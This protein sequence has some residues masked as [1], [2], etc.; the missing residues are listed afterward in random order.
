MLAAAGLVVA[1]SG[2]SARPQA[3]GGNPPMEA[4]GATRA[5]AFAATAAQLQACRDFGRSASE[6][7]EREKCAGI[8][9]IASPSMP[10][11][12]AGAG[13]IEE[14]AR[15]LDLPVTVLDAAAFADDAA[16]RTTG[17]RPTADT[18]GAACL[19]DEIIEAGG[20]L[21]YPAV[22]TYRD[23]RPLGTA[24]LGFKTG[25]AYASIIRERLA[26]TGVP[27][28]GPDMSGSSAGS[29]R[30]HGTGGGTG[31]EAANAWAGR[32]MRDGPCRD[33]AMPHATPQPAGPKPPPSD[34]LQEL[35]ATDI[36]L[37]GT[38]GAYFRFVHGRNA[39]SYEYDGDTYLIDLATGRT[40]PTPGFV[41]F[42]PSPDGRFF[43]TPAARNGGLLFYD[44]DAV[45]AGG[46]GRRAADPDFR[47]RAMRDQYP[48]VGILSTGA[49][50]QPASVRYRILT[51]WFDKVR[52]RDYDVTFAAGSN[53]SRLRVEP[54]GDPVIAC[55][56]LQVSIPMLSPD[57]R[58]LAGRNERTGRTVIWRLADNGGCMAV[59]SLAY[60]TSKVAWSPDGSRIAFFRSEGPAQGNGI[61]AHDRRTRRLT[62]LAS[63]AEAHRLAFP[64]FIG[65]DSVVFIATGDRGRR[66]F[67]IVCCLR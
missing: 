2:A 33:G 37:E 42:I 4:H 29:A 30:P 32:A 14:A 31:P 6:Q 26:G 25:D 40:I 13:E 8:L 15:R 57:G 56:E 38:P 1:C 18:R 41:D 48:S 19:R 7:V 60:G 66:S 17:H 55:P 61:L 39:I 27:T 35:T 36:A 59:D 51:S 67:R 24:L 21:H 28:D 45:F 9:Y 11:S 53:G 62:R 54:V 20:T 12:A 44:A 47:D 43:V 64:D 34:A 46:G 63:S 22:L 52:F 5:A 16:D 65:R 3:V 10:L 58:E 23:G 50:A 49:G